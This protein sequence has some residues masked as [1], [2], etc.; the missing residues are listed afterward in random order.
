MD[1]PS[2]PRSSC[3]TNR[4]LTLVL[5]P[6]ITSALRPARPARALTPIDHL[7]LVSLFPAFHAGVKH[8][9]ITVE[10]VGPECQLEVPAN[11]EKPNPHKFH[12][13][14]YLFFW[15]RSFGPGS[16]LDC[17]C[18][19]GTMFGSLLYL[20]H[21]AQYVAQSRYIIN[22]WGK[23]KRVNKWTNW[24]KVM[25]DTVPTTLSSPV[26]S[27]PLNFFFLFF[28]H[29][30]LGK[31]FIS[32]ETQVGVLFCFVLFFYRLGFFVVASIL[33]LFLS[34]FLKIRTI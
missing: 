1:W 24:S 33:F 26:G 15:S 9:G 12:H 11:M 7:V 23:S 25:E 19:E 16:S 5:T 13:W 34:S 22:V 6:G 30:M 28:N 27:P 21:L 14:A 3:V 17:E 4:S 8:P 32:L 31:Y 29:L 20:Y 10:A 18:W 2:S